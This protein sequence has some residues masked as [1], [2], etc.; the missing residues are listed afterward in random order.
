M[1]ATLFLRAI[2]V[3]P[4][5]GPLMIVARTVKGRGVSFMENRMEWHYLPMNE[6][7]FRVACLEVEVS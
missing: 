5:K 1:T 3:Q 4:P 2:Q 6:E 7:Q